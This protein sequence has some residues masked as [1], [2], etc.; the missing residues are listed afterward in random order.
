MGTPDNTAGSTRALHTYV[1]NDDQAE[2]ETGGYF[3]NKAHHVKKGDILMTSLDLAGAPKM[4][5]YLILNVAAGV[6]TIA[7]QDV[8]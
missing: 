4:R 1:S 2:V 7:D 3:N 5:N 6:V 8:A